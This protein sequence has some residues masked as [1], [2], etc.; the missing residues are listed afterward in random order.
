MSGVSA[1]QASSHG[2]N[3]GAIASWFKTNSPEDNTNGHSWC[4]YPYSDSTPG[5]APSLS[6]MLNAAGGDETAAREMWCGREAVVK[7]SDGKSVTLYITDAFDDTWVRTPNSID[8]VYG[9]VSRP[10]AFGLRLGADL[11]RFAVPR[12]LRQSDQQQG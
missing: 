10:P 11:P 7:T 3:T 4:W 5:F 8:V 12:S 1:F 6:T 2:W 9:S